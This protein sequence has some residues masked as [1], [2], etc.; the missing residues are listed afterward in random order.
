MYYKILEHIN[1]IYTVC[2]N[3]CNFIMSIIITVLIFGGK[4]EE[5][6]ENYR[7]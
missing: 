5:E 3:I 6:T 2:D 7:N 1:K 4:E